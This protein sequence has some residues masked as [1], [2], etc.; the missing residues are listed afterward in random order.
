VPEIEIARGVA[1]SAAAASSSPSKH[2]VL[3]TPNTTR[4]PL[5]EERFAEL[6]ALLAETLQLDRMAR[7]IT[8]AAPQARQDGCKTGK[9]EWRDGTSFSVDSSDLPDLSGRREP[10]LPAFPPLSLDGEEGRAWLAHVATRRHAP[11]QHSVGSTVA[12][13]PPSE[14]SVPHLLKTSSAIAKLGD[15]RIA[16]FQALCVH[17]SE[18]ARCAFAGL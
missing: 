9:R 16:S 13:E 8:P 7:R 10:H 6:G 11:P 15:G 2:D 17:T 3:Q 18:N 4:P 14:P 5:L 1:R 12:F